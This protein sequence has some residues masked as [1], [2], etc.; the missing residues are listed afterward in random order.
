MSAGT[1]PTKRREV[2]GTTSVYEGQHRAERVREADPDGH[3]VEHLYVVTTTYIDRLYADGLL[4]SNARDG[5]DLRD[6]AARLRA[7]WIEADVQVGAIRAIEQMQ[8][9]RTRDP[10]GNEDAYARYADALAALTPMDARVARR[11]IID[12]QH[13][14][15]EPLRSALWGLVQHYTRRR[16]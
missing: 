13:V 5:A 9:G 7:D 2:Y 12:E 15:L 14:V 16:R 10:I 1:A 8:G 3:V 4:S 6:A 11:A